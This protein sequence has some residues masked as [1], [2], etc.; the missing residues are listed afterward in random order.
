MPRNSL[1]ICLIFLYSPFICQAQQSL[2]DSLLKIIALGKNDADAASAYN[3]LAYEYSRKDAAKSKAYLH[4]AIFIGKKI[5]DFKKLSSSYSILVYLFH[6]AGKPDS[7]RYYLNL[8]KDISAGANGPDKDKINSNYYTV[9]ALYNK[10]TGNYQKAIPFF[11]NAIALLIKTGDKESI[12]GQT[13]NLGNTYLGLGNY[14]KATEQHLKALK[15]FEELASERGM[16]FCYQSLSNSFTQIKQYKKAL[17]YANK[18]IKI[19]T[20]L[21]DRQGLG[22]TQSGLGEIYMGYGNFDKALYHFTNSLNIS[23]ELKN[24]QDEQANYFNIAKVYTA[25]NDVHQAIEYFNRSKQLAIQLRDSS[26]LASIDGE[27]IALQSGIEKNTSSENK[28][29]TTIQLFEA[30]GDLNRQAAGFKNMSDFYAANKQFEKALEYNNKYHQSMDSVRNNELQLQM[31]KMEEQY[32][33][34]KKEKE[35]TILKKDQLINKASLQEQKIIKYALALLVS[36]LILIGFLSLNRFRLRNKMKQLEIRNQIAAD[37]HDEVGS[38]LSSILMLSEMIAEK[39]EKDSL[40]K[41]MLTK[42]SSNAQ[43][44]MDKMSDIVWMIKPGENEGESLNQRMERFLYDI[45]TAANLQ[46]SFKTEGLELLKLSMQQRKGIYLIFKEAVN[47][48][49]KYSGAP[50]IEVDIKYDSRNMLL[51]IKDAGAGFNINKIKPGNGLYN[52]KT[53]A[54]ELYGELT[55]NTTEGNGT[56][57]SLAFPL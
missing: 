8:V 35:I 23:K 20:A 53:R 15:I 42:M 9:A 1:L 25:K 18:S 45:G 19:K 28:L 56:M 17:F 32:N 5:N 39:S 12:A 21:K 31:N 57:I 40:Q 11:E 55:I 49:V 48:A 41:E 33:V 2:E 43:E 54:K 46:T 16:S 27:L 37:L 50:L 26:S 3:G 44:T 29:K 6:D 24:L 4:S 30:R 7:A 22:T 38:S 36:L 34:E 14:Q 47:N 13:L 52:M 51:T 10:K